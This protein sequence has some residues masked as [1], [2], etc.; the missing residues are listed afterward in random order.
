MSK[1]GFSISFYT[2]NPYSEARA[3][4][5]D[6]QLHRCVGKTDF[7]KLCA[8]ERFIVASEPVDRADEVWIHVNT[9]K[10]GKNEYTSAANLVKLVAEKTRETNFLVLCGLTKVGEANTLINS[11][12]RRCRAEVSEH[13]YVGGLSLFDSYLPLWTSRTPTSA[14]TVSTL[15]SI[16]FDKLEEAEAATISVI[17]SRVASVQAIVEIAT[18][19]GHDQIMAECLDNSI[20]TQQETLDVLEYY[21]SHRMPP[22]IDNML[23]KMRRI[24]AKRARRALSQVNEMAKKSRKQLRILFVGA[25]DS[26][27]QKMEYSI[28]RKNVRFHFV[29]EQQLMDD[30]FESYKGFDAVLLNTNRLDLLRHFGKLYEHVWFVPAV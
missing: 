8:E 7:I 27:F 20:M 12:V 6:P 11:F 19:F 24:A 10:E 3:S 23:G 29:N 28:K 14:T 30:G 9:Y 21:R 2:P 15:N 13:L 17:F 22:L 18:H 4:T 26:L 16:R 25:S 5:Y 1:K